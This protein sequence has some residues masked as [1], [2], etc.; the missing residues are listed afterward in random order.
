LVTSQ[1]ETDP[2]IVGKEKINKEET[3]KHKEK[4]NL[5]RQQP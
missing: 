4:K 3:T 5:A 1:P 2:F